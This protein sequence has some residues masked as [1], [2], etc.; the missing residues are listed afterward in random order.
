MTQQAPAGLSN[1]YVQ[2]LLTIGPFKGIDATTAPI[3]VDPDHAVDA[4]NVVPDRAYQGYV[5]AQGRIDLGV[6]GLPL[7]DPNALI[8]C[9]DATGVYYLAYYPDHGQI[10]FFRPGGVAAALAL[11]SGAALTGPGNFTQ[12]RYWTFLT[13]NVTTDTPLKIKY[14][15]HVV[16]N[17]GIVAPATALSSAATG[18]GPLNFPAYQW[19]VT[20]GV[21]SS[22]VSLQ[23]SSAGPSSTLLSIA[24]QNATLSS[25][26]VSGDPQVNERNIYRLDSGGAYRL[27]HTIADNTTTTYTDT[28]SDA[29]VAGQN[30]L[31]RDPP[32]SATVSFYHKDYMFLFGL[33]TADAN[34]STLSD[35]TWANPTEPW[36]FNQ[37]S[38][39]FP[40]G[41]NLGNDVAVAG[42]STSALGFL[43]K[44]RTA[45][46]VF[47]DSTNDFYV[48]KL[49]DIGC[50]APRSAIVAQGVTFWLSAQGVYAFDGAAAP[51]YLS[52]RIKRFLE[53][54]RTVLSTAVG[55]YKDRCYFLSFPSLG[56]TWQYD[57]LNQEWWKLGWS[58]GV[59]YSDPDDMTATP[60]AIIGGS[61]SGALH[62]WFAA[63][64]D[65]GLNIVSNYTSRI[66]DS[67]VPE[68]TKKYRKLVIIAPPQNA[69]ATATITADPGP[70]QKQTIRTVS[71]LT[72][73]SQA[74]VISLPPGIEGREVQV[75]ISIVS[76]QQVQIQK[77][78]L[79]GWVRRRLSSR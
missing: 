45:Y 7:E 42:T 66:S 12:A 31:V 15:T 28:T 68:A 10:W 8:K 44:Q 16:T 6:T 69:L 38:Q 71:L 63:E 57:T 37:A 70:A 50:I 75:T 11:P 61:Q 40:A 55:A 48:Q 3:Y 73:A 52:K 49:F 19:V 56:V 60:G 47:G 79:Y 53:A 76:A 4:T 27:V 77:I 18:S 62:Q 2:E 59:F 67:G 34:P 74:Q 78:V 46:G 51:Q 43:L 54:N 23:E 25:I 32:P 39:F 17:W 29:N 72:T 14:D 30:L 24:N 9:L 35:L 36:G 22:G 41:E 26:P 20:F 64:T 1:D 13:T 21:T 33:H 58:T 65:L 5:T